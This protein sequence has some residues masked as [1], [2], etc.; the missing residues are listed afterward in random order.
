MTLPFL[1]DEIWCI[2]FDYFFHPNRLYGTGYLAI[3]RL[4]CR[5]WARI[6]GPR[7][8]YWDCASFAEYPGLLKYA[9]SQGCRPDV[10]TAVELARRNDF[11]TLRAVHDHYNDMYDGR[12]K[13]QVVKKFITHGNFEATIWCL[14]NGF[15][16]NVGIVYKLQKY[17]S[18]L[19]IEFYNWI[20]NYRPPS[21]RVNNRFHNF[22]SQY[23]FEAQ[24]DETSTLLLPPPRDDIAT[25]IRRLVSDDDLP[26]NER[27][28]KYLSRKWLE[29]YPDGAS[30]DSDD[31]I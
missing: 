20:I 21:C 23:W 26:V 25:R 31:E 11:E 12:Q 29:L 9:V 1:P 5:E 18:M 22:V 28:I 3:L 19:S 30:A 7:H 15:P 16:W 14:K 24:F 27:V 13:Q 4:V 17:K 6:I 2:I 10:A 8:S